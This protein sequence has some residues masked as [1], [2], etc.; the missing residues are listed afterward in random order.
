MSVADEKK[1]SFSSQNSRPCFCGSSRNPTSNM[2]CVS[3]VSLSR[4]SPRIRTPC[5]YLTSDR[6]ASTMSHAVTATPSMRSPSE[7]VPCSKSTRQA[8]TR[9]WLTRMILRM[10]PRTKMH[11]DTSFCPFTLRTAFAR[12]VSR[13]GHA[14]A[15]LGEIVA[16]SSSKRMS[17]PAVSRCP[18]PI[19]AIRSQGRSSLWCGDVTEASCGNQNSFTP[20]SSTRWPTCRVLY[21]SS[22]GQKGIATCCCSGAKGSLG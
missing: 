7:F 17:S 15:T 13:C 18:K 19:W 11:E 1:I 5:P 4:A 3:G 14:A 21:G 6:S 2:A 9:A 22:L 20:R 8:R 16:P 12:L 10:T